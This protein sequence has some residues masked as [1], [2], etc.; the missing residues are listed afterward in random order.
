[1]DT[2][3]R[4][5]PSCAAAGLMDHDL[6]IG[7]SISLALCAACQK[8]CAHACRH[9]DTDGGYIRLDILHGIINCHACRYRTAGAVDV[10]VDV[11]IGILRRQKQ[12]LCHNQ[13]C[14][15][16]VDLFPQKNDS[17]LQQS[18]IN[19]IRTFATVGLFYDHRY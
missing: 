15:Y 3:I 8:K 6:C 16:I 13:T 2:D 9:A 18:G 1:M 14:G 19:I 12:Q 17:V 5:L 4:C 11:L 7:Q 10:E